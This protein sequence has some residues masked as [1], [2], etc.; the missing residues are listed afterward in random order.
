MSEKEKKRV[1]GIQ[2]NCL[3]ERERESTEE[4]LNIREKG[5][6]REREREKGYRTTA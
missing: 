2:N 5:K 6:K 3:K 4:L 1:R